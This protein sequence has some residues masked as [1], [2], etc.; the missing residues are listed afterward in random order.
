VSRREVSAAEVTRAALDRLEAVDGMIRAFIAYFPEQALLAAEAVDE[1]VA[2]GERLPLAGVPVAVKA[3]QPA[4]SPHLRRL[5]NAGAVLLGRTAV[6]GPGT[7]WQTWGHTSRGP[8]RNPWKPGRVPGGSS[9]GSAAAVAAGIVP[10]ATASDGAGSIR[11]PAA[12]CGLIGVKPT[13]VPGARAAVTGPV[14]RTAADAAVFLDVIRPASPPSQSRHDGPRPLRAVWSASLGFAD[15]AAEQTAIARAAADRLA[16]A[17]VLTWIRQ[18][19]WLRDPELAWRAIR[20]GD[21]DDPSCVAIRSHNDAALALL[22]QAADLLLTPATPGGP[23]HHAGPGPKM[24]VALTWAFNLSG[25]PAITIPAGTDGSGCP[26]GLQIVA[27]HHD[28]ARLLEVASALE[29]VA[30]WPRLAPVAF[31]RSDNSRPG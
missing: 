19:A 25:H 18:T 13:S 17:G 21:P 24:N 30:P 23:H 6:P 12:W 29:L 8:T 11:I 26:A 14:A 1:L 2:L 10:L 3:S 15:V 31:A 9:A 7:D 28:D 4:S 16:D 22:F 20:R 27:R 5:R